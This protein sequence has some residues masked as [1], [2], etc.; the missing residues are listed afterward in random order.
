MTYSALIIDSGATETLA[1]SQFE[2]QWFSS[3][4]IP[5]NLSGLR[6]VELG[7]ELFLAF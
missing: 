2:D 1:Q 7:T 3:F 4:R 6:R 5:G